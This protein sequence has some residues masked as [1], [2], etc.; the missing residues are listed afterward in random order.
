[1]KDAYR[2]DPGKGWKRIADVPA[3]VAAAPS[4]APTDAQGF[5]ILGGDDGLQVD[6]AP[7][8]HRGFSKKVLRYDAKTQ[9]WAGVGEFPSAQATVPCV[10]WNK[11]WVMPNGEIRPGVRTPEVWSWTPGKKE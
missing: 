4:P 11:A 6:T 5:Y 3:P 9:K 2:Y 10:P 7:D 8:M 1:L